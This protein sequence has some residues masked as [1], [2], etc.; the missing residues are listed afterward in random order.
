M[1]D[2]NKFLDDIAKFGNNTLS[3]M[4]SMQRQVRKWASEQVDSAI[5][6][7]DLVTRQDFNDQSAEAGK[8]ISELER[9]VK[10]L[11]A[12]LGKPAS[13]KPVSNKKAAAKPAPKKNGPKAA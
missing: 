6:G 8:R 4:G 9:R 2:Y 13:A 3:A 7:M 10:E 5:R 12:K 1:T 11:E